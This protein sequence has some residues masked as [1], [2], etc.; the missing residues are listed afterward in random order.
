MTSNARTCI[1]CGQA[2]TRDKKV[3]GDGYHRDCRPAGAERPVRKSAQT[4]ELVLD[5]AT[6]LL[7]RRLRFLAASLESGGLLIDDVRLLLAKEEERIALRA[8]SPPLTR[9]D[10]AVAGNH[11]PPRE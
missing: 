11:N 10:G 5:E 6:A 1:G 3:A 9:L 7:V 8:L 4:A 2:G